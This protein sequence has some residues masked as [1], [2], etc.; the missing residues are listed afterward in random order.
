MRATKENP[1]NEKET[2]HLP[3]CT[4]PQP[5]PSWLQG[6]TPLLQQARWF[7]NNDKNKEALTLALV[8]YKRQPSLEALEQAF[9]IHLELE[10]FEHAKS[11]LKEM[12]KLGATAAFLDLQ[13]ATYYLVTQKVS[14]L[15]RYAKQAFEH[16]NQLDARHKAFL[17]FLQGSVALAQNKPETIPFTQALR[18]AYLLMP[19]ELG[20]CYLM[21]GRIRLEQEAYEAAY[22]DAQSSVRA[23]PKNDYAYYLRAM[24][25]YFSGHLSHLLEDTNRVLQS[26][27]DA[28]DADNKEAMRKIQNALPP[29]PLVIDKDFI[30]ELYHQFYGELDEVL[31]T[32]KSQSDCVYTLTKE[33]L[34]TILENALQKSVAYLEQAFG[35]LKQPDLPQ[36][37][38]QIKERLQA[39]TAKDFTPVCL[40][41]TTPDC[42]ALTEETLK[43]WQE[44]IGAVFDALQTIY[45]AV[46]EETDRLVDA[47]HL[48]VYVGNKKQ[49]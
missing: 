16:K 48:P 8:E 41:L 44:D 11:L 31:D 22:Q 35:L 36:K 30:A 28:I 19:S 29:E 33:R 46:I 1:M 17:Y 32:L 7:S 10:Q 4:I 3:H 47:Y 2:S 24:A 23:Y 42:T 13:K 45:D 39:R 6:F 20:L 5:T 25:G 12:K 9:D 43:L 26:T 49:K 14:L 15:K 18:Y 40:R 38:S 37:I 27:E 34:E 21:R